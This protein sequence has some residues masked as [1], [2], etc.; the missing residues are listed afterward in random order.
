MKKFFKSLFLF[1][2]FSIGIY[3]ILIALWGNYAP[4]QLKRN[5]N[6]P[7]VT[8]YTC[9]RIKNIADY[10]DVDILFLGSSHTYSSFDPRFYKKYGLTIFNL[11]STAQS[12]MQTQLLLKR[13]LDKLNPKLI[14]YDVYPEV[15]GFD[16]VESAVNIILNDKNDF[17][18]I[19]MALILNHIK[20]Y[21]ALIYGF[22]RDVFKKEVDCS[23]ESS[24]VR[25]TYIEGGFV[26]TELV[27]FEPV[28]FSERRWEMSDRQVEYFEKKPS[29]S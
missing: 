28:E 12:P 22:Y 21:N 25:Q 10:K 23:E 17:E 11:G 1:I 19:K 7:Y 26:E 29:G 27:Y 13:Y 6:F 24:I 5:L 8:G 2:P 20:V 16:G 18:S 14:V 4:Y 3:V 15:F 9:S